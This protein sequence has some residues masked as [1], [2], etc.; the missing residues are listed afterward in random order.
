MYKTLAGVLVVFCLAVFAPVGVQACGEAD[1]GKE[2][3]EYQAFS[4]FDGTTLEEIFALVAEGF[5]MIENN[6]RVFYI[7]ADTIEEH[8]YLHNALLAAI[9]SKLNAQ[10]VSAHVENDG[11]ISV[12]PH[13]PHTTCS[14]I[15]GHNWGDEVVED[16]VETHTWNSNGIHLRCTRTYLIREY[17]LR[18]NCWLWRSSSSTVTIWC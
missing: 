9:M 8:E 17:C 18:Q 12:E 10:G 14:N 4:S 3:S 13:W 1:C 16:W 5:E 6:G 7:T 2:S 15:L 11:Y